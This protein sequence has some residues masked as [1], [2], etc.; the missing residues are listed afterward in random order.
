MGTYSVSLPA[1]TQTQETG[2]GAGMGVG[3]QP[4]GA[5]ASGPGAV[6]GRS[7]DRPAEQNRAGS[8]DPN[9]RF[10]EPIPTAGLVLLKLCS[11]CLSS[12]PEA[13]PPPV[14]HGDSLRACSTPPRCDWPR[15]KARV[16]SG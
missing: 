8:E 6:Q 4:G 5:L 14:S 2:D 9:G 11:R 15:R 12:H 7:A 1:E 3:R 10:Q 13:S 16:F